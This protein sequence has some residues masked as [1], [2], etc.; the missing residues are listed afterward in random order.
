[1]TTKQTTTTTTL[2][3]LGSLVPDPS[4]L[5][6]YV[7]RI[8]HG[9]IVDLDLLHVARSRKQ[10]VMLAGPTGSAKT[11]VVRAYAA[12]EELPFYAI[13]MNGA[14]D[15]PQLLGKWVPTEDGHFKW[16]DGPVTQIV[17]NGGVLLFDELNFAP[18]KILAAV[19][20]LLD[21][22]RYLALLDHEGEIVKASEDL[23][24]VS[25]MNP[26]Y[27]GTRPL[28]EALKNRFAYQVGFDYEKAVEEQ[29]V[30]AL[31][32]L[33]VIADQLRE[34]HKAGDLTTPISTNRLME[35]EDI[36]LD[37]MLGLDFAKHNFVAAF[38]PEE[39]PSVL[40]VL[41]LHGTKLA[42]EV[43]LAL[44]GSDVS[45]VSGDDETEDELDADLREQA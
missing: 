34:S 23:L 36:S 40:Q 12:R 44:G 2:S 45:G 9:T 21:S 24:I 26:D 1:M 33:L 15:M 5:E 42:N 25:A 7:P 35:F 14:V 22:R 28:N 37:P 13:P 11:S 16:I 43:R 29:L 41:T 10:N 39:Q 27:E 38:D 30:T 18:A 19:F 17:R 31:P 4:I 20:S 32:T 3:D 8:I 6:D